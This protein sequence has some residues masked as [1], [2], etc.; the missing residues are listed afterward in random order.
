[1][2][3]SGLLMVAGQGLAPVRYRVK[4]KRQQALQRSG[5][6]GLPA[7]HR[8]G[9]VEPTVRAGLGV[10]PRAAE[11]SAQQ[12]QVNLPAYMQCLSAF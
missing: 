9:L 10:A 4:A 12:D 11:G 1:M 2:V 7:P 5:N 3:Q 8:V 6:H